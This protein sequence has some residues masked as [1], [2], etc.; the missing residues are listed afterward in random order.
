MWPPPSLTF[1]CLKKVS[2]RTR[3]V[4]QAGS[5]RAAVDKIQWFNWRQAA[6]AAAAAVAALE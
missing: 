1:A 3:P 5:S 6:A 2:S 4:L